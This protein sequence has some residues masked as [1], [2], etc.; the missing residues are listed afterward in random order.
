MRRLP[1]R[2]GEVKPKTPFGIDSAGNN[3]ASTIKA[4]AAVVATDPNLG[5]KLPAPILPKAESAA[6]ANIADS[7]ERKRQRDCLWS[8]LVIGM[9]FLGDKKWCYHYL[10]WD[11]CQ[12]KILGGLLMRELL[13]G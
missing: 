13:L 8:R 12:S 5:K 4:A 1:F 10:F 3:S 9:D 7:A 2:A 6:A 11:F